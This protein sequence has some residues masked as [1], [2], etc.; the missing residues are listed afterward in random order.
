MHAYLLTSGPTLAA[1]SI[2]V[3]AL[4]GIP[5]Q[6][7]QQPH[8]DGK[9]IYQEIQ[10]RPYVVCFGPGRMRCICLLHN[11]LRTISKQCVPMPFF[12]SPLMI[13]QELIL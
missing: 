12:R 11:H 9:E 10:S 5:Q 8:K 2:A 3:L 6:D 13:A 7:E 4:L 1:A